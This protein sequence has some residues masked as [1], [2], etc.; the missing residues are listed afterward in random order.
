M[1][2][3]HAFQKVSSSLGSLHPSL[4][5]G[6]RSMRPQSLHVDTVTLDL[7]LFL[8]LDEGGVDVLGEAVFTGDEHLLAT[9][10]LELGSSEGLLG[11]VHVL[12][13]RSDRDQDGADADTSRFTKGLAV[14][15]THTSLQSISACAGKHLIDADD[16]PRMYSDPDVETLLSCVDL[17]VFVSGDT[18]CL[19]RLR[20]D[21]LL[22]VRDH[23]DASWE[24]VPAGLLLATVVHSD[25]GIRHTTVEAG[26]GVG[27]VLLVSI[28]P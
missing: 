7:A 15:V 1:V 13:L 23:M 9:W 14:G 11:V 10:E 22:F 4:E 25:L 18:G 26:L 16:V 2:A 19:Q 27:L 21:L 17:H 28:T 24:H 3:F 20:R 12:G 6:E 5:A 8:E